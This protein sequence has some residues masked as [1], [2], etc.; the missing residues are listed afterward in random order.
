MSRAVL[1]TLLALG[2]LAACARAAST[3]GATRGDGWLASAPVVCGEVRGRVLDAVSRAPLVGAVV[4]SDAPAARATTGVDGGFRLRTGA[5]TV[6]RPMS[7]V[8]SH[9]GHSDLRLTLPPAPGHAIEA[10]LGHRARRRVVYGELRIRDV[11]FCVP[12]AG[13]GP[14]YATVP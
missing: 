14:G 9:A 8:V 1:A 4:A 3:P 10:T 13:E 2:A 7:L 12:L 6:D 5:E 11:S